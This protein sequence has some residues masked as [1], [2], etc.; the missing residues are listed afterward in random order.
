[1]SISSDEASDY[2]KM[3]V[4]DE[5]VVHLRVLVESLVAGENHFQQLLPALEGVVVLPHQEADEGELELGENLIQA[6]EKDKIYFK[7]RVNEVL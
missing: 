6:D 1:M 5:G 2:L 3:H 4:V 7:V